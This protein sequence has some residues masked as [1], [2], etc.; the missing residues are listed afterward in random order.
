LRNVGYFSDV[1][2][3][4]NETQN[5]RGRLLR[6]INKRQR[7]VFN[8]HKFISTGFITPHPMSSPNVLTTCERC[9]EIPSTNPYECAH[10]LKSFCMQCLVK[11]HHHDVK[12]EFIDMI[13]RID[14]ILLKFLNHAHGQTEWTQH[15]TEDRQRLNTFIQH[16]ESYYKQLPIITLPSYKWVNHVNNLIWK[17]SSA[18]FDQ[19]CCTLMYPLLLKHM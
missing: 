6:T 12:Y 15:L 4:T 8:T 1:L 17:N 13:N 18:I 10:C 14:A 9:S 5:G 7:N 11:H 16:I 3:V 19:N 2:I